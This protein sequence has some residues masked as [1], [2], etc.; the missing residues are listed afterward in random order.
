MKTSVRRQAFS[1]IELLAVLFIIG[2]V[3]T[4]A[5]PAFG[6][7]QR[8]LK[9]QTAAESLTNILAAA[10]RYAV[11]SGA[12]CYVAFPTAGTYQDRAYKLYTEQGS[13][14]VP[15][16]ECAILNGG[17]SIDLTLS[18]VIPYQG[19]FK[20]PEENSALVQVDYF[21]F[22][23]NGCGNNSGTIKIQDDGSNKYIDVTIHNYPAESTA[24]EIQDG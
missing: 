11:T 22:D 16:G 20:F 14:I 19:N 24:G 5:L 6:P 2:I 13:N 3:L 7:L 1:L 18:S 15:V 12:N 4:I 9:L 17:L 21:Y 10:R 23:P 8:N